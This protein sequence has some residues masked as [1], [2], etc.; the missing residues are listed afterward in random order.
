MIYLVSVDFYNKSRSCFWTE[1]NLRADTTDMHERTRHVIPI[2]G[3]RWDES[4]DLG[5]QEN[6]C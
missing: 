6:D 1:I 4:D 3:A 2:V 5:F